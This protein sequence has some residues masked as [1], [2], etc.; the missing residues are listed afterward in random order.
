MRTKLAF[1]GLGL[2]ATAVAANTVSCGGS[3]DD[4]NS[5][6]SAGVGVVID[7]GNDRGGASGAGGSGGSAGTG[8]SAG[9]TSRLGSA[10]AA[11]TDCG[12]GLTCATAS[13]TTFGGKG[14]AKG[15]CTADC[16]AD[17]G[18]CQQFGENAVCLDFGDGVT[19]APFCVQG[20][21]FG[22]VS[23]A[24]NPNKCRG[25]DEIACAPL[26]AP[27]NTMC[28]TDA[29]C[30]QDEICDPEQGCFQVIP[31]CLPQCNADSDCGTG[32]YCDPQDGLCA[33]M[34]KAGKALGSLCT[35]P[36]GSAPDECRGTCIGLVVTAGGDPLTHLCAE[37][38]TIGALPSCGWA[39]PASGTPANGLCLFSSTIIGDRGGPGS[40]DRGSCAKLCNC[41]SDCST[42]NPDLIC[43]DIGDAAL[44]QATRRK[45]FCTLPQ[46]DDGGLNPGIPNCSAD[47]GTTDSGMPPRD[48]AG[49]G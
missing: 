20:C 25:R 9:S 11:D 39:G 42:L 7:S 18:S 44:A 13:S 47:G 2:W 17:A 46:E 33:P 43:A 31:A 28:T 45:G 32:L 40:G 36:V 27:T 14:P 19:E 10:C 3:D 23:G 38:C 24:A 4:K 12:A 15:Y 8:G 49:G 48:A 26:F 37:N 35:Q 16:S 30:G 41:N 21:S 1:V 5:G 22:P 34:E 29:N 6:G